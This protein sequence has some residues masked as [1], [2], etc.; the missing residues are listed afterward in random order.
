MT[1]DPSNSRDLTKYR[2]APPVQG[3]ARPSPN[4]PREFPRG[5]VNDLFPL[6][7]V[8]DRVVARTV[9]TAYRIER[10]SA[11]DPFAPPVHAAVCACGDTWRT[12]SEAYLR[13]V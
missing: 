2:V 8:P 4:M 9:F 7:T 1:R 10:R 6:T 3:S 13:K 11:A 5:A 12:D